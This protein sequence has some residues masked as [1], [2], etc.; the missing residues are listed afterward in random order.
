MGNYELLKAA[1]NEVIKANGRQEIT[2]E[3]LNQVLLSMVNSLGTGYQC[4]GVATPSTNPGTPD[5]NVFYFAT[6]AGTYTN[7][8]AIVLQAGISVLIWDGDWASQTWFTVDSTPTNNSQNLIA[9]GAVFNALKLD[10]GAYDVTAHNSGAT[11]ASLSVLLNSENLATLIPTEIRHGGMSIKFVLSSDNNY[12]Q[13]RLMADEWSTFV[14]DWQSIDNNDVTYAVVGSLYKDVK[15]FV[16]GYY[17]LLN[18]T[19]N[20]D[21]PP[22]INQHIYCRKLKVKT[23]QKFCYKDGRSS[24]LATWPWATTDNSGNILTRGES[25]SVETFYISIT[26][27]G[28]LFINC[29]AGYLSSLIFYRMS[30]IDKVNDRVSEISN[31]LIEVEYGA[32]CLYP[33]L[34]SHYNTLLREDGNIDAGSGWYTSQPI[35]W[36]SHS[37]IKISRYRYLAQ[38]DVKGNLVDISLPSGVIT[39]ATISK[40][41]NAYYLMYNVEMSLRETAMATFNSSIPSTYT[42]FS[43]KIF[44][45]NSIP[46]ED[47]SDGLFQ[48]WVLSES[49]KINGSINYDDNDNIIS[50][51]SVEYPDG[52]IGNITITRDSND[53]VVG[54]TATHA[55]MNK[56]LT[57]I[58]TRNND[59][60]IISENITIN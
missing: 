4:M 11:F 27:D 57:A 41:N 44:S 35:Y 7:F 47:I 10:G 14:G 24:S 2:G 53:N 59:G 52:G 50:P 19:I 48:D 33:Y 49:Y 34:E 25:R 1:I 20:V 28:Y 8:D 39:Y 37:E 13:Y 3:V 42:A 58:F 32:N 5:Q 45:I 51:I 17:V 30:E 16:E 6:Q 22:I 55:G 46:V 38:Y 15:G 43:Q 9:S 23:G 60:N 12:V 56:T 36:G 29:D 40:A 26:Q 31:T 18:D 54:L 21:A